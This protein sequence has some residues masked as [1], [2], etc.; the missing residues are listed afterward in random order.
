ML[1]KDVPD[2]CK[3]CS[4][5]FYL[6]STYANMVFNN[7][8]FFFIYKISFKIKFISKGVDQCQHLFQLGA[9]RKLLVF[10]L[11]ADRVGFNPPSPVLSPRENNSKP[12]PTG[13][14]SLA[15]PLPAPSPTSTLQRRWSQTQAKDFHDLHTTLAT[16]I[17]HCDLQAQNSSIT[18]CDNTGRLPTPPEVTSVLYGQSSVFY[19][20]VI[21]KKKRNIDSMLFTLNRPHH[22]GISRCVLPF[23]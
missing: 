6:L 18:A 7:L 10:L 16:M 17:L 22:T 9:F 8:F 19:F 13:Q 11:G 21:A 2:N 1:D 5:F 15:I 3:T 12:T 14:K 4:Q 23:K 20:Q